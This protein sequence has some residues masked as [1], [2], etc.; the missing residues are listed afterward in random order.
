MIDD[1][2]WPLVVATF[3]RASLDEEL[4][5]YLQARSAHLRRREPH[6]LILDMREVHLT[7]PRQRQR[8][9][10]W[11]RA[12]ESPLRQWLLG[13]AYLIASPMVRMMMS[14]IRHFGALSSPF[15]S[16][17]TLPPAAAWT[18]ERLGEAG[19]AS[20]AERIRTHYSV[21]SS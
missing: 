7:S 17:T 12:H 14:A 10:E 21:P 16:T 13:S 20:A 11:L 1:G 3:S 18:A 9:A 6:V 4:E 15:I 19:L 8:Y 2:P 5:E